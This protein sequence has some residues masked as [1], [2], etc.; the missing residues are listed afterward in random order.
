MGNWGGSRFY[1]EQNW[2]N[3]I[4]ANIKYFKLENL[5]NSTKELSEYLNIKISEFPHINKN[6]KN[7]SESKYKL[8]YNNV[9]KDMVSEMYNN[10]LK[11]FGY[12]F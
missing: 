3:D 1:F 6:I 8:F 2:F 4:N 5:Q 12:E 11:M 7:I 9:G 10:D